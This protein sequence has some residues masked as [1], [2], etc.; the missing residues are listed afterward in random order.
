MSAI[1]YSIVHATCNG[2]RSAYLV[3]SKE[4]ANCSMTMFFSPLATL[5]G[6]WQDHRF[7][8]PA[9]QPK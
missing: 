8:M 5:L 3:L 1:G 9:G 6:L 2:Y 4:L 7:P